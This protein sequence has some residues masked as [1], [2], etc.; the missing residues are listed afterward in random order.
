MLLFSLSALPLDSKQ[1]ASYVIPLKSQ[2]ALTKEKLFH[3]RFIII[4][5]LFSNVQI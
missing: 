2:I 5:M 1:L 3:Y 4:F